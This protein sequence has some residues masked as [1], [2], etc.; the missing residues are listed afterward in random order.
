[1][2][3]QRRAQLEE[4]LKEA[5]R[6]LESDMELAY[7]DYQAQMLREDLQR[8][9]QELERLEAARRE[10]L[11]MRAATGGP[12][13]PPGG[14]SLNMGAPM[15]FGQSGPFGQSMAGG[16]MGGPMGGP[17]MGGPPMG[18]HYQPQSFQQGPPNQMQSQGG[19]G[20][21]MG[22]GLQGGPGAQNGPG[23]QGGQR[24]AANNML[25]GV[26]RLLQIFKNEPGQQRPSS[27]GPNSFGG[28]PGPMGFVGGP[29]G[30]GDYPPEK[31]MRR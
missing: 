14:P 29:G 25:E 27:G 22:A 2:E 30:P 10:R 28:G 13:G 15:Q 19:P 4:E 21:P 6:R 12:G 1:M 26:Q 16:P 5:R 8:R 3:K 18:G 31:R 7:Q 11:N 23:A 20:G 9:Q 17:P 24:P